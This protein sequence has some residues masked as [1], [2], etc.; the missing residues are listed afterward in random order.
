MLQGFP[1]H[2]A[3]ALCTFAYSPAPTPETPS[4]EPI[5]FEGKTEGEIV[6]PRGDKVF[7]WD[8]V[9]MPDEG[10]G[11]TYAEM[12]PVEKNKISHRYKALSKLRE[13]L[14]NLDQ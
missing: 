8:P 4:P 7:G 11:L 10:N 2:H 13:Y 9:F 3:H 6:P 12:D 14:Q 1:T 5:L